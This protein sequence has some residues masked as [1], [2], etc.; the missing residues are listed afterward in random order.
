MRCALIFAL[1]LHA[2]VGCGPTKAELARARALEEAKREAEDERAGTA[3]VQAW[4]TRNRYSL[5]VAPLTP[6]TAL[7]TTPARRA[8]GVG[9]VGA[10]LGAAIA[11]ATFSASPNNF[12]LTLR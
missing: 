11:G 3:F 5:E 1:A 6:P 7:E 2:V 12:N 10:A 4:R 8:P 9:M